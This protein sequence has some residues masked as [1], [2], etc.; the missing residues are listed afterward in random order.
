M[1]GLSVC[2]APVGSPPA[3]RVGC[4]WVGWVGGGWVGG[5]DVCGGWEGGVV[6]GG[7]V[8]GGVVGGVCGGRFGAIPGGGAPSW[9]WFS[10]NDQPSKPPAMASWLIAATWLKVQLPPLGAYQYDQ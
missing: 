5:G 6:A 4:A 7:V 9:V 2:E 10:E 8:G 3:W 1:V